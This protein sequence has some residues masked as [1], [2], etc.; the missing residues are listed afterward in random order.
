MITA[1]NSVPLTD[2]YVQFKKLS[3]CNT[4]VNPKIKNKS[5]D[6]LTVS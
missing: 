1:L 6:F 3:L 5:F 4:R 2:I